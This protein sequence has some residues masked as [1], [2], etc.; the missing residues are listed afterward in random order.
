MTTLDL[1]SRALITMAS[2]AAPFLVVALV[3]GLAIALI[4]TATQLQESVLAFVPKLA[5]ALLVMADLDRRRRGLREAILRLLDEE[6]VMQSWIYKQGEE[7]GFKQGEEKGFKRGEEKGFKRGEE[8]ATARNLRALFVRRACRQPT[9][10]EERAL[11]RR[12][13]D[14]SPEQ[15]IELIDMPP[16]AFLGWLA[17]G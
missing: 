9:P 3:V 7:K 8:N 15:L 10:E 2:V 17:A 13:P 1:W 5:A 14:V 12:A 6:T 11:A 16:D 4:Q